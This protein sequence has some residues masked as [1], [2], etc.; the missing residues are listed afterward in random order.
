MLEVLVLKIEDPGCFWVIIKGCRQFLEQEVDYQ[1]LN[2]A[3]N[4]FYS[5]M[6]QDIEIKPLMLEEG[7]VC[8]VYCQE[9][10]CWCRAVI[11]SIVSSADH[12]LAECFLV[13]F[14]KCIPVKSKKP[15]TK[16]DSAAIQYFQNILRETTQVEAKLCAVEEDTFEVYLYATIK[17]EKDTADSCSVGVTKIECGLGGFSQKPNEKLLRLTEKKDCDEKNGCV[18]LLQFLNPDPL[19]AD[20]ISDLQQLQKVKLG[21]LQPGVVLRNRIEPCLTLEKS[22]LSADLKKM[23]AILD[24]FK[25]NVEVE[26]RESAPHQIVAVGVHW[27]RHID[28]LVR[29]F[30][31][32]PYVVITA[33][34]EAALYGNV[35]QVVHLC[36]ECE[37]TS[38][39]LQILDFVPSQAQKTLIFT[40]SVAETETV[41]KGSPAEQ[42]NKKTKSVLLLTERNASQAVGVL[43]YLERAD[44]KIPSELY[45]F[46]AGVLEAKEDKKAR[47]P[48]CSYLKAFGFCKVQV[49]EVSQKEDNWGLGSVLVKFIDEGRTKLIARDKLLLLPEKFHTLPPQAVEFIVCR[50]KPADSEIEWNPKVHVTKLSNLKTSIIDYNV[51]AEILSMGMGIDNSEHIE[52]LKKLCKEAKLP[53][54]EDLL[55]QTSTPTTVEDAI[56]LQGTQQGDGDTEKSAASKVDLDTQKAEVLSEDTGSDSI[57]RTPQPHMRSFYPQIKWFQKDDVVI[58]KIKIRN[59]KDYKCKFFTDRVIFSAW[60]GDKFYLADMELQG[61][62]RKDDCKCVIKDNEPLITLAKEKRA[63]WRSLLKQRHP[64]VAFDFDHWEECEEDSP[65]SKVVNSKNLS[66]KV[67]V[68]AE[69]SGT[70]SDTTDGSDSE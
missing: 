10:K 23:F 43:R 32:D 20:E 44:A 38:T 52:Q 15:A 26:E 27:N 5:S 34:E 1:K 37:K 46:T 31:K 63:R 54:F 62:I 4:D 24:N 67:A 25:K 6:S 9:L 55:G 40:C 59:V 42:G 66:C 13:D 22:P 68:L 3:M 65:F 18:K 51:R 28:H 53:A 29:E 14:A 57:S 70:S 2:N 12:Y 60:V 7:Q 41:C 36:L 47:R 61:D 69:N 58:L 64:N 56:C 48:L 33:L 30:M 39:L 11:K 50:V 8:V 35:Q 49:L 45:E 21:T 17:N 19:R 16:W